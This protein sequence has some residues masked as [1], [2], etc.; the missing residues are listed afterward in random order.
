MSTCNYITE[1]TPETHYE[2]VPGRRYRLKP[3]MHRCAYNQ[4]GQTRLDFARDRANV[5]P[6][7]PEVHLRSWQL[8]ACYGQGLA[9][10]SALCKIGMYVL[11]HFDAANSPAWWIDCDMS[12]PWSTSDCRAFSGVMVR[13]GFLWPCKPRLSD[14]EAYVAD[15]FI[16]DAH[17]D[18]LRLYADIFGGRNIAPS[19]EAE[20]L[21]SP[22]QIVTYIA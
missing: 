8:A 14:V 20:T 3:E 4:A 1:P 13:L 12:R 10:D 15:L 2:F 11:R 9:K 5:P 6:R 19:K 18:G 17:L 21:L 16:S 7:A 22:E